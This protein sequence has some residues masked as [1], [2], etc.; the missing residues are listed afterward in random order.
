MDICGLLHGLKISYNIYVFQQQ[1]P[2]QQ[3]RMVV[4]PPAVVQQQQPPAQPPRQQFHATQTFDNTTYTRTYPQTSQQTYQYAAYTPQMRPVVRTRFISPNHPQYQQILAQTQ[5]MRPSHVITPNPQHVRPAQ[6]ANFPRAQVMTSQPRYTFQNQI[7]SAVKTEKLS[8]FD[9]GEHDFASSTNSI[10]NRTAEY[11]RTIENED[12]STLR[13]S[14]ASTVPQS[15]YSTV[16]AGRQQPTQIIGQLRP[17]QS[18]SQ[19]SII[20]TQP[21]YSAQPSIISNQQQPRILSNRPPVTVL[22]ESSAALQPVILTAQQA[23]QT[24]RPSF[25]GNPV[26]LQINGGKSI[27]GSIVTLNNPQQQQ[28]QQQQQQ[29]LQA[30]ATLPNSTHVYFTIPQG[31]NVSAAKFIKTPNGHLKP[32]NGLALQNSLS[33]SSE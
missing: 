31:N 20:S 3:T 26:V 10:Y 25:Q 19:P 12:K 29:V 33:Q 2:Q 18:P 14:V 28:Q 32:V 16:Y 22:T 11:Q 13:N 9:Y 24:M 30:P 6:Q 5:Q 7:Q 1:P 17:Q 27:R 15:V 8:H 23:G 4:A 21:G